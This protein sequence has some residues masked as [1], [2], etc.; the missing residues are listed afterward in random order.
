MAGLLNKF[1]GGQK[2]AQP[3]SPSSDD[4]EFADFAGAPD[5]SPASISPVTGSI[6]GSPSLPT[7]VGNQVPYTKWYR[8][9]ERTSR[10]DFLLEAITIPFIILAIVVHL[11]GIKTNRRIARRW[12][13]SHGPVL[14][15]EFAV[16]GFAGRNAPSIDDVQSSG[17]AKSMVNDDLDGSDGLLKEKSPQDFASYGTGRKNVAF[18]D[19]KIKLF[20]RYNPIQLVGEQVMSIFFDSFAPPAERMEAILY[21][22]DGREAD[23]VPVPGGKHGQEVLEQRKAS[24]SS[25]YDDF[26]WAI[27]NKDG[28]KRLRDDRYDV[29]LTSTKDHPKLPPWATVMSENAEVTETLLQPDLIEAVKKAGDSFEFLIVTDQPLEKPTKLN[30]TVPKKRIY[31][32]YRLTD[33]SSDEHS[34]LPLFSYFLR[35]PDRLVA[36]AHFR[37]EVMRKVRQIRED[38]IR[39]LQKTDEG[40]KAEERAL[41]RDRDRK[42][43]RD[44]TLKGLSA[45]EQRKFLDKEREKEL[46][47]GQKRMTSRA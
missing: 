30:E 35:L 7:G 36:S 39:K 41:K 9:W 23:I 32:S 34:T 19:V 45:E 17:L 2:S 24:S 20:K 21:P 14:E 43:K 47:K 29:S 31:L 15:E 46:K 27:V 18:V 33:P 8:V 28:M 6:I 38:Q 22:F 42:E 40:E 3:P 11:W 25:T 4:A 37:P 10:Q 16:V 5:P 44:A 13:T 1:F 26:V 12:V